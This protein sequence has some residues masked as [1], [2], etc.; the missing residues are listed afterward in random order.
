MRNARAKSVVLGTAW[1]LA[2]LLPG[3]AAAQ[4]PEVEP[5]EHEYVVWLVPTDPMGSVL[6]LTGEDKAKYCAAAQEFARRTWDVTNGRHRI[7]KVIFVYDETPPVS[8]RHVTWRRYHATPSAGGSINMYDEDLGCRPNW[9]T[10]GGEVVR[11]PG[12][13]PAGFTCEATPTRPRCLTPENEPVPG[14]A[15]RWGWVLTHEAGHAYYGL[16]DEY[17]YPGG[18][19][20][21]DYLHIC[22]N[23]E[24]NTS[25]MSNRERDHWCDSE[26]HLHQRWILGYADSAGPDDVQVTEPSLAGYHVWTDAQATWTDLLDYTLGD[27]EPPSAFLVQRACDVY[28][29][30]GL[31]AY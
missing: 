19:P 12:T 16:A 22:N 31:T 18:D 9:G 20:D 28:R 6:P 17:L 4:G 24:T 26:T 2:A 1:A 10:S 13:C 11:L 25:L 5:G 8:Q 15:D 21:D 27:T 23:P 7:R 14:A 3:A 29:A 30:A